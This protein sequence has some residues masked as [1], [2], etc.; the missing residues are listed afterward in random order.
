MDCR[1]FLFPKVSYQTSLF[2]LFSGPK[3]ASSGTQSQA[4][5]NYDWIQGPYREETG[6]IKELP[7]SSLNTQR[8]PQ[9]LRDTHKQVPAPAVTAS[10]NKTL[11]IGRAGLKVL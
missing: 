9:L 10:V 8:V 7:L 3:A 5:L 11:Q 1:I 2:C 6:G 4:A